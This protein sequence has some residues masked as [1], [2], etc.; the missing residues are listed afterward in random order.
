MSLPE[1]NFLSQLVFYVG[2]VLLF[3]VSIALAA[4]YFAGQHFPP[5]LK[6]IAV[7]GSALV[8]CGSLSNIIIAILGKDRS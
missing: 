7:F 4:I 2:V 3:G 6:V 5:E 8:I 1:L